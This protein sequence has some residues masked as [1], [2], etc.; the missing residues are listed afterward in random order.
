MVPS[1]KRVSHSLAGGVINSVQA[2][3][4]PESIGIADDSSPSI[5]LTSAARGDELTLLAVALQFPR[6]HT[7]SQP[8]PNLYPDTTALERV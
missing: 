8:T 4:Q 7:S 6:I 1:R 5:I 3:A 2:R